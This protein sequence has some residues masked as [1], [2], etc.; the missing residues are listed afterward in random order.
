M[1]F[2]T[3]SATF[4]LFLL[5]PLLR[6]EL[7]GC[8]SSSA[9]QVKNRKERAPAEMRALKEDLRTWE[10]QLND[11]KKLVP[12]ELTYNRIIKEEL[13]A[14]E[15]AAHTQEERLVPA[16]AK[17]EETSSQL[18]ELKDRLTDLQSLKKTATE[19]NR[20]HRECEDVEREVSKLEGE[21]SATGSTATT[22]DIQ[23]QLSELSEQLCVFFLF[24][25]P[26]LLPL[27]L[28]PHLAAAPS[29]L[30]STRSA[31]AS[32]RRT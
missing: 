32:K 7:T 14:S 31:T 13:P 27:I 23:G 1:S 24:L 28:V 29:K 9:S 8:P 12:S 19:V 5:P 11:L 2:Q 15:T 16:R 10:K 22:E 21:L 6:L 17:A 3:S 30:P 20:L 26:L 25:S 4:V 18:S